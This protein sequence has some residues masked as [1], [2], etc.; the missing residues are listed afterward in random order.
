[1]TTTKY[2]P[3]KIKLLNLLF[4]AVCAGIFLF[5]WFAPAETTPRVPHDEQHAAFFGM[6]KK[7]AEKHCPTC[8]GPDGV[9]PLPEQHPSPN[10]C[11]FCHKRKK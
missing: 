8:H 2:N 10:R 5:L 6:E 4:I 9:R 7:P 11:L 3:T 1:M